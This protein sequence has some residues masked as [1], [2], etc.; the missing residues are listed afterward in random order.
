ML[1]AISWSILQIL[2]P[3]I[4]SAL[5]EDAAQLQAR[6]DGLVEQIDEVKSRESQL[7]TTNKVRGS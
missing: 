3:L 5:N 7:R 4:Q 2:T 1:A 6:L